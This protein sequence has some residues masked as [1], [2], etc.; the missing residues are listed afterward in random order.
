MSLR[1]YGRCRDLIVILALLVEPQPSSNSSMYSPQT[2]CVDINTIISTDQHDQQALAQEPPQRI[3]R[4]NTGMLFKF[5]IKRNIYSAPSI[6][7]H[8]TVEMDVDE[9]QHKRTGEVTWVMHSWLF[10][11]MW[12]SRPVQNRRLSCF[13]FPFLQSP[14]VKRS[15]VM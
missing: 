6:I 5:Y 3:P 4:R 9:R 11:M 15:A 7:S 12:W 2:E 13:V 8:L 10:V 1:D 14:E